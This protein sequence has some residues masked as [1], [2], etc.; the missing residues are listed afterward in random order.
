MLQNFF[1][2]CSQQSHFSLQLLCESESRSVVSD[3]L[4]PHG[5]YSP[6]NS[7]GQNTRVGSLTLLQGTFPTQGSNTCL[8]HCRPILYQ[9]SHKGSPKILVWVAYPFSSRS[10]WPRDWTGVSCS[11]GWFFTN[12]A[13][14]E[15]VAILTVNYEPYFSLY[16]S[17]HYPCSC[18][19]RAKG[20]TNLRPILLHIYFS[21]LLRQCWPQVLCISIFFYVDL[22]IPDS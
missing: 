5:L 15:S 16:F 18:F 2:R 8:P 3:S 20:L 12:W 9:L 17:D 4:R 1:Q 11:A 13:I 21:H 6:W 19:S 14:R 10:S 7:P 22:S